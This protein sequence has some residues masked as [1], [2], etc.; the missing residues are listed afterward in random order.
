MVQMIEAWLIADVAALKNFYGKDFQAS[1]VPKNPDV[2]QITDP[3]SIL[4][5]A[6][7]KTSKGDYHEIQHCSKI[8]E[9]LDPIK[10]RKA[11]A[12]CDRLFTTLAN[13]MG[14]KI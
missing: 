11:S 5:R 3:K 1:L 10:V 9:Q 2:E 12:Y 8:L 13:K 6:T 4:K 14:A 7:K